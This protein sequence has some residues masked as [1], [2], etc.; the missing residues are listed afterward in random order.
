MDEE[1]SDA[2]ATSTLL[3]P[4]QITEIDNTFT[5][6]F[7]KA[8]KT[9]LVRDAKSYRSFDEIFDISMRLHK[10]EKIAD[11]ELYRPVIVGRS[12]WKPVEKRPV[13]TKPVETRPVGPKP[14]QSK[15]IET[16]SVEAQVEGQR[17][18]V[19]PQV[20]ARKSVEIAHEDRMDIVQDIPVQQAIIPE[21]VK[22]RGVRADYARMEANVDGDFTFSDEEL[23]PLPPKSRAR[24]RKKKDDGDTPPPAKRRKSEG[25]NVFKNGELLNCSTASRTRETKTILGESV[26]W[27]LIP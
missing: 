11:E 3:S 7:E 15:P 26:D 4:Q 1:E 13:Q 20:E 16:K 23:P 10:G 22:T 25:G 12:N 17:K 24:S 2:K 21:Q 8:Q 14:V 18:S 27:I 19:G 5:K 9:G 6:M